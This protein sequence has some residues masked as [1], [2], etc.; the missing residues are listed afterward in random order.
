MKVTTQKNIVIAFAYA[1]FGLTIL[2]FNP[3]TGLG[4]KLATIA[5][6]GIGPST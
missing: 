3:D 5:F 4:W 2:T 1:A 6:F